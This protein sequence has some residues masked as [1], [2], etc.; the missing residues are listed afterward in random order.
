MRSRADAVAGAVRR[1]VEWALH[2]AG[3]VLVLLLLWRTLRAGG[4]SASARAT[5]A[6]LG[7]A[8]REWSVAPAVRTV[9]LTLTTAPTATQRD[10][11]AALAHAG[12]R[13][14]WTGRGIAPVA[15]EVTPAADP[16]GGYAL[17]VAAPT[18]APVALRDAVGALDSVTMRHGAGR[19]MVPWLRGA[20]TAA[21]QGTAARAVPPPPPPLRRLLVE[22][23]AGWETKFVVAALQERGWKVDALTH[24][25][26]GVDVRQGAPA[27]PDTGR[28]A[29]VVIVD[30]TATVAAR[31]IARYVASGGGLVTL[32]DAAGVGPSP[33]TRI[34]LERDAAGRAAVIAGRV[35]AGRV[36]RV[37]YRDLWRRRM[38]DS[39][40][41]PDPVAAERAWLAGVIASAAFTATPAPVRSR[42]WD[43]AAPLAAL[44]ALLGAPAQPEDAAGAASPAGA[45][46]TWLLCAGAFLAFGAEWLSRRLR[47]AR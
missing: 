10:W 26:P 36:V 3:L 20:V 40:G 38:R 32:H 31:G 46:P 35:G 14:D 9:R 44:V 5:S 42:A 2:V 11:L 19:V 28:Y 41:L 47:G 34:V 25:A 30:S 12:V 17:D 6:S 37:A 13:V 8:L 15:L 4:A 24:V 16:A 33:R 7:P 18:G 23:S 45:V 21:V 43:E 1:A 29:A 27:A 39:A 22:G